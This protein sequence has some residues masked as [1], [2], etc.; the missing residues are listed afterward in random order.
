[1]K[2]V[3]YTTEIFAVTLN[4]MPHIQPPRLIHVNKD[5]HVITSSGQALAFDFR[6]KSVLLSQIAHNPNGA[7]TQLLIHTNTNLLL[8]LYILLGLFDRGY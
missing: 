2:F 8:D 4:V 1:M 5:K 3:R 7:K 6:I